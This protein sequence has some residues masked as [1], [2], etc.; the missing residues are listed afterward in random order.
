M[1]HGIRYA[2]GLQVVPLEAPADIAADAECQWVKLANM[3]WL[4][5][6]VVLGAIGTSDVIDI[7]VYSTTSTANGTTNSND[8]ALP[9]KYRLSDA[10]GGDDWGAITAVTTATGYVRVSDAYDNK[11]LLID[12][13]P[14]DI[15]KHDSDATYVYLNFDVTDSS[16]TDS[17]TIMGV[18]GIFEQRYPQHD[19][20]CSTSVS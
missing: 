4:S 1:T 6:L 12:V 8:Y 9:F 17:G 3:Q 10:E 15:A 18:V 16:S 7:Y 5:F 20:V 14:A 19:P 13:D 11:L 2:E